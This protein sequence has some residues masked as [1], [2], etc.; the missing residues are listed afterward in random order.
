[1]GFNLSGSD[2][3]DIRRLGIEFQ[4]I[5]ANIYKTYMLKKKWLNNRAFEIGMG[6]KQGCLLRPLLL[7]MFLN[8]IEGLI[9]IGGVRIGDN[10]LKMLAYAED[11]V[12]LASDPKTLHLSDQLL[13]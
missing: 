12:L 6:V 2:F 10:R 5:S 9:K 4:E 8:D 11:M 13:V 7:S 1:M 3:K